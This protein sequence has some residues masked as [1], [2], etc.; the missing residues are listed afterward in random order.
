MSLPTLTRWLSGATR[1]QLQQVEP[2]RSPRRLPNAAE[3]CETRPRRRPRRHRQA[4]EAQVAQQAGPVARAMVAVSAG[5]GGA[6]EAGAGSFDRNA[7]GTDPASTQAAVLQRME[8]VLRRR[9]A[10]RLF[11]ERRRGNRRARAMAPPGVKGPMQGGT[12]EREAPPPRSHHHHRKKKNSA[13]RAAT[14]SQSA[15]TRGGGAAAAPLSAT[16]S[17]TREAQAATRRRDV[18][19]HVLVVRC[20]AAALAVCLMPHAGRCKVVLVCRKLPYY[21]WGGHLGYLFSYLFY[22]IVISISTLLTVDHA[23]AVQKLI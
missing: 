13:S 22:C 6:T 1:R 12:P 2:Q 4:R 10:Q 16:E 15:S 11:V 14:T 19:P 3:E 20:R 21:S 8:E 7:R 5:G 18:V 9:G 17:R 23:P